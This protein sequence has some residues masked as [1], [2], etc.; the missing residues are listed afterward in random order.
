MY[1]RQ[2]EYY[3]FGSNQGVAKSSD[4]INWSSVRT[5]LYG[6]DIASNLDLSFAGYKDGSTNAGN[7]TAIWAPCVI[8][9]K[10][11][12]N[13]DGTKGAYMIYYPASSNYKR[14]VIGFA[15]SQS[16][17]GP[18]TFGANVVYSGF[19]TCGGPDEPGVTVD[20]IYTNTHP[21]SYTHLDVYKRQIFASVAQLVEQGTENPR[22]D[23]SIPSG[24]TIYANV[25]HL[26]ERHLAKVEVASSSLVVRSNFLAS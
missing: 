2:G 12:V 13:K 22:V 7:G 9:N 3:I 18:Y 26:V 21:V 1:K 25:A 15:T 19:T 14:G 20:T 23:G 17:T 8:Y 6:S 10:D 4:L 16:I 5:S 11:F 24:G